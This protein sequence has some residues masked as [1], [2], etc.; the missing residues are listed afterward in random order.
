MTLWTKCLARCALFLVLKIMIVGCQTTGRSLLISQ[1]MNG[2][3][4]S[5][6]QANRQTLEGSREYFSNSIAAYTIVGAMAGGIIGAVIGGDAKSGV[7]GAGVGA[8]V[9]SA[10]GYINAKK[11]M[12]GTEDRKEIEKAII[13]DAQIDRHELQIAEKSS[14]YLFEH[15]SNTVSQNIKSVLSENMP[16]D[17]LEEKLTG[18]QKL[19]EDEISALEVILENSSTR[20]EIRQEALQSLEKDSMPKND[21]G[22]KE[23]ENQIDP[24][25]NHNDI[26][27]LKIYNKKQIILKNRI[28]RII[29]ETSQ[30]A[31]GLPCPGPG[32]PA[33]FALNPGK[34]NFVAATTK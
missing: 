23:P 30:P 10:A 21:A 2:Q 7:I 18:T 11:E 26:E 8:M 3:C 5:E 34:I 9:G 24:R 27:Y 25:L 4:D 14:Q 32:C 31:R 6:C 13:E 1:L 16:L 22:R 17:D 28:E 29:I 15:H 33:L 19:L 12:L 20:N